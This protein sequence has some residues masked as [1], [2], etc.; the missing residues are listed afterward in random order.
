MED[1]SVHA[2]RRPAGALPVPSALDLPDRGRHFS[3][4]SMRRRVRVMFIV[5][6]PTSS[7]A[8]SV[9]ANLMRF[10]D[11]DRVEVHALYNALAAGEPYRSAENSVL[12]VLPRDPD[13]H[14][15]PTGFGP[16]R[17]AG[18]RGLASAAAAAAWPGLRDIAGQVNYI[19]RH[20]IDI[21]H[22]EEGTRNGFYALLLSRLTSA[23]L[24]LHFHAQYGSWLSAPARLAVTR[25][26]AVIAVSSWTGRGI[27]TG[28]VP[29]ERIFPVLNGI[30][31]SRWDPASVDGD[32]VRREFG[33]G[34]DD[35]LV[36]MVAQ[37][38]E[39]KRQTT[40]VEAFRRVVVAHPQARLL[41][42]GKPGLA[43]DAP[44]RL[45][46]L[47]Q[48]RRLVAESGLEQNVTFTG[49]RRDVPQILAAADIFSLPSVGEPFGLAHI[50]AMAMATPITAV[51]AGGVPEVVQDGETGLLSPPEDSEQLGANLIALI[52]APARRREM[53]QAGR[54][55]VRE[56]FHAKRM[57]DEVEG[58]YR[59]TM[60]ST[61][62]P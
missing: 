5:A 23:K 60:N 48:L 55:R 49:Q 56:Y 57:A 33:V 18:R 41:L 37:L 28:G 13:V 24:V 11:R 20:R 17:G 31:V 3:A 42:V 29:R 19:R 30:D 6:P 59:W 58:V 15:R 12:N 16:V 25:A 35:P 10:L 32:S 9:H 50:E 45:P 62:C 36:V 47:E 40:L 46:Y 2:Y 34:P 43:S 52:E 22:T 51:R 54:R 39:W 4:D 53:G 38:T 1:E 14:L 61:S 27:H 44:G 26:Q 8:I 7:P 21:I